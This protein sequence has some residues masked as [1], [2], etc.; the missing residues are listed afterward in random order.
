MKPSNKEF[1]L[2]TIRVLGQYENVK[3]QLDCSYSRTLFINCCVGLLLLSKEIAYKKLPNS[4]TSMVDW[5][6]D[7]NK[8]DNKIGKCLPHISPKQIT[9]HLRN[10]ISH[11]N[12]DFA[13][14]DGLSI[15]I[16]H[17]NFED[18]DVNGNLT[19]QALIP[20][21]EFQAFVLKLSKEALMILDNVK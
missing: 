12:F 3:N 7:I 1:I 2:R 5:G 10:S 6:I 8:N 17:I 19:F 18:Y 20:F 16:N 13:V 11:G 15:P 4:K 21:S 9:R 14:E